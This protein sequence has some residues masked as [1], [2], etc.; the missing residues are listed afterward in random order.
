MDRRTG[1]AGL[2]GMFRDC[3]AQ[4]PDGA[5]VCFAGSVAVCTPFAELLS[6]AVKDRGFEL[7]YMP[8]AD[9]SKARPIKWTE[10]VGYT[11]S[12]GSADPGRASA[13]VVL[14]GLAMPK[15]GCPVEA[16]G[17]MIE[18]TGAEGT[19]VIGVG[20]MDIFARSGWRAHIRFDSV[21]NADIVVEDRSEQE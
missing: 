5:K 8:R 17:S 14:G 2:T 18:R 12:D 9:P 13:I 11:V 3:L 6:Y 21:I 1:I 19:K 7:I 15:F 4:V 16:V 20:F 10:G